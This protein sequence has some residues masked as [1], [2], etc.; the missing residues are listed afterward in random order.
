MSII[1]WQAAKVWEIS[2]SKYM[3]QLEVYFSRSV[4]ETDDNVS[5]MFS[6]EMMYGKFKDPVIAIFI[7]LYL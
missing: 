1:D 5:F 3:L 2:F 6:A 7:S 4:L